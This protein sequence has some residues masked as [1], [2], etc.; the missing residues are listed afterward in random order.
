MKYFLI[1]FLLS[2][3]SHV[4]AKDKCALVMMKGHVRMDEKG[5]YLVVAEKTMSEKRHHVRIKVQ[6]RLAPYLDQ[7]VSGEFI[8]SE[9]KILQVKK[10]EIRPYDPLYQ[11]EQASYKKIKDE[12]C[13]KQ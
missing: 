10:V 5:T 7:F 13:P 8:V 11:N 4:L 12:K 6:D 2:F 1:G 3:T 9:G